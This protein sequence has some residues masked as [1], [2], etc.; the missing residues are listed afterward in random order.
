MGWASR[1]P[2]VTS[3]VCLILVGTCTYSSS[4]KNPLPQLP[5]LSL[6]SNWH[7]RLSTGI[8]AATF[9]ARQPIA[10]CLNPRCVACET[11]D[12]K[13]QKQK[14]YVPTATPNSFLRGTDRWAGPST[15]MSSDPD[16]RQVPSGVHCGASV[17]SMLQVRIFLAFSSNSPAP[18]SL[19]KSWFMRSHGF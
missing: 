16:H 7:W 12:H 10:C 4:F 3:M 18:V 1:W 8:P 13:E 6:S 2:T 5:V 19:S 17:K 11:W 14:E 9:V 15:S